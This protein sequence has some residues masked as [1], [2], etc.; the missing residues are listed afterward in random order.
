[1]REDDATEDY[2]GPPVKKVPLPPKHT[3]IVRRLVPFNSLRIEEI[4]VEAHRMLHETAQNAVIFYDYIHI[5]EGVTIE[6]HRVF[7]NVLDV[8]M[9]MRKM[10]SSKV[11]N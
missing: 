4:T 7:F 3:Y 1:M 10:E 9:V 11:L 2:L 5:P 8:E 6:L